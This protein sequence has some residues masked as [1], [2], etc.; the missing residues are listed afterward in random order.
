M[1]VVLD[2][3]TYAHFLASAE[4]RIVAEYARSLGA[5]VAVCA[6]VARELHG[7]LMNEPVFRDTGAF[8]RWERIRDQITI[9]SDDVTDNRAFTQAVLDLHRADLDH[10]RSLRERL[11]TSKNL[12]EF[13]TAAH[14]LRLA[15]DGV[16]VVVLVDDDYGRTL[17]NIAKNLLFK[18]E[19]DYT[20]I[21]RSHVR[22][23][24][25][26]SQREW[27]RDG[28]DADAT[29]ARMEKVQNIPRWHT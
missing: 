22:G 1:T 23:L 7:I 20:L 24:V 28:L 10:G 25:E 12:G 17:V 14:A 9:L 6:T 29:L 16:H 15:R 27:R 19:R 18:E 2:S 8:E 26:K 5:D 21:V 4:E 13:M 3:S 11:E